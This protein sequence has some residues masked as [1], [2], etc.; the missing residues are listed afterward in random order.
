M[1]I[2]RSYLKGRNRKEFADS[3]KTTVNVINN[4]CA[5]SVYRPGKKLAFRIER[6]TNGQIKM[7]DLLFYDGDPT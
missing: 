7:R 1:E 5:D 6:I 3:V 4:L 2:L